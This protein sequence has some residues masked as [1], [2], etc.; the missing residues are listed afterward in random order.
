MVVSQVASI[1]L[2]SGAASFVEFIEALTLVLALG[3]TRGWRCT[4]SGA[5]AALLL[6]ALLVYAF[7]TT[8]PRL[9]TAPLRFVLGLLLLLFGIRWLRKATR[10]SAGLIPLRD[11]AVILRRHQARFRAMA[12][13][14][15][16]WDAVALAIAFQATAL[17]GLEVVFIVVAIGAAG[18]GPL[19]VAAW[20]AAA[21]FLLVCVL[22]LMLRGPITRVPE[23][24]LKRVLSAMLCGL[25]TVWVGEGAGLTW[26]GGEAAILWVGAAFLLLSVLV[27]KARARALPLTR[28]GR[29]P[30]T[31]KY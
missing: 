29:R 1:A 13:D 8:L 3:G 20:G 26:P 17:E 4:L 19:H 24:T 11:E 23:N 14:P 5:A 9:P 12:R 28:W 6:L 2:T 16:R 25:G 7:G 30:Q 27:V 22:G 21:A 18:P 31:R 15:G 10:R